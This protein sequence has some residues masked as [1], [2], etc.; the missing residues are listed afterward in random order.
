MSSSNESFK[1]RQWY[2]GESDEENAPPVAQLPKS[3]PDRFNELLSWGLKPTLEGWEEY[4]AIQKAF[5]EA[6]EDVEM[7][8]HSMQ[9]VQQ[10]NPGSQPTLGFEG[11]I[12]RGRG[13]RFPHTTP[14]ENGISSHGSGGRG[15][16]YW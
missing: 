12:A 10:G 2:G 14:S 3:K 1:D 5:R 4:N 8:D 13:R 16:G 15:R 6:E 7:E 11:H 9:T